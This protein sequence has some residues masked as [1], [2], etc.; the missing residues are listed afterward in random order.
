MFSQTQALRKYLKRRQDIIDSEKPP[1]QEEI[2][3]NNLFNEKTFYKAF[4]KDML[5][6]EEEII[7]IKLFNCV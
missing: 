3:I 1:V 2:V 7:K 5:E 4:I 6:A